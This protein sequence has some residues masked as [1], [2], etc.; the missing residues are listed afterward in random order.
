VARTRKER[1]CDRLYTIEICSCDAM[2]EVEGMQFGGIGMQLKL[3]ESGV[4]VLIH[5]V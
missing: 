5:C 3:K 2:D 4:G 1:F